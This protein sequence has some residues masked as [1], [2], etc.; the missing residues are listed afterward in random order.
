MI[1]VP[2]TD[3][4]SCFTAWAAISSWLVSCD[5]CH[6]PMRV[7]SIQRG[8]VVVEVSIIVVVVSRARATS[9]SII[10]EL[11]KQLVLSLHWNPVIHLA[12]PVEH[13]I[14]IN[15]MLAIISQVAASVVAW[16]ERR[17]SWWIARLFRPRDALIRIVVRS[18]ICLDVIP[19][20][21]RVIMLLSVML[22]P[23]TTVVMLPG[24][25]STQIQ[26]TRRSAKRRRIRAAHN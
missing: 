1:H 19:R 11:R 23:I 10:P 20:L 14:Q 7:I 24:F 5:R 18:N 13:V 25:A 12:Q 9:K 8:G 3:K 17:R 15:E 21:R 4:S 26:T 16:R 6:S 2:L 22:Q